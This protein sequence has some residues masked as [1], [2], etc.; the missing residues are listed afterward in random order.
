MALAAP[1]VRSCHSTSRRD[2]I[3][4]ASPPV[5]DPDH[6]PEVTGAHGSSLELRSCHSTAS[7]RPFP[8]R[9]GHAAR[10]QPC[11]QMPSGGPAAAWHF[12]RASS[13][14]Y[15]ASCAAPCSG[16]SSPRATVRLPSRYPL[17]LICQ[18][19]WTLVWNTQCDLCSA[20]VWCGCGPCG[21][22]YSL[23]LGQCGQGA[24]GH[25]GAWRATQEQPCTA[26]DRRARG[27][28]ARYRAMDVLM[29][30]L[31]L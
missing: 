21:W 6:A 11:A 8:Q 26:H 5:R 29:V 23:S 2:H 9:P 10:P 27:L 13:S 15:H 4:V 14:L 1:E 12:E 19:A 31:S 3:Q 30:V 16:Q 22:G 7:E 18:Y 20:S 24:M 28:P 17:M 25:A